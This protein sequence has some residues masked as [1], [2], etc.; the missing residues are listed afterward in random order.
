MTASR[1]KAS[2]SPQIVDETFGDYARRFRVHLESHN[3][4][5]RVVADYER[6]I[7]R[8]GRLVDESGVRLEKLTATLVAELLVKSKWRPSQQRWTIFMAKRFVDYLAGIGVVQSEPV[9]SKIECSRARLRRDY[10]NYL[11]R[12][13]GVSKLTIRHCWRYAERFLEYRFGAGSD[14]L[15]KIAPR[16]IVGFLQ[17]LFT[18]DPPFRDTTAPS[19]LRNFFQYLFRTGQTTTNLAHCVP[20][21]THHYEARLPRY[22]TPEQIKALVLAVKA[23][24]PIGRRN[25]AMILLLARLGLR[26]PEVV[27]MHDI[28]WRAGEIIIRGK[29]QRHDRMPLPPDVGEA[30]AD[31]IGRDRLAK[32]RTLFVTDR[33][34]HEP[35]C[36]GG[37]LNVILKEA[38]ARTG[39]TPPH[40]YTGSRILRHSLATNLLRQGAPLA[41]I[42][43]MLRH[44]SRLSTL[45]YAKLDIEGLRSIAQP[46]PVAEGMK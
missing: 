32:S 35:F 10:E 8:L 44:R 40:P 39:L 13:R 21:V 23:D 41:E 9:S 5:H 24:S 42:G 6:C 29:G 43:D 28:D 16:D 17:Y 1:P 7:Q 31:Y 30:L 12:E 25:Y 33:A 37:V 46:W 36:N 4:S 2:A 14:D 20:S 19:N 27:A 3:Y 34:P 11:H 22:L 38:F 26:A 18:R 45:I 15:S